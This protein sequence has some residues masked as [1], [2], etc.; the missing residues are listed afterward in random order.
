MSW[1]QEL[2][3][4]LE[5]ARLAALYHPRQHEMKCN[6]APPGRRTPKLSSSG[7]WNSTLSR[8]SFQPFLSLIVVWKSAFVVPECAGVIKTPAV[9]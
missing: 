9:D 3:S 7:A 8:K 4:A 1:F 5:C 2:L 6:K